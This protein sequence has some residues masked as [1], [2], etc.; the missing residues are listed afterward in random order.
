MST[1]EAHLQ[2]LRLLQKTPQVNQRGLA[3]E[4]GISLGKANYCLKA[5]IGKGL[6]KVQNFRNSE[7]KLSYAYL[8]TPLGIAEKAN[9]TAQFLKY[10][11]AEYERLD[12]EIQLLR[13]EFRDGQYNDLP[14]HSVEAFDQGVSDSSKGA[15][16]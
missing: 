11:L 7:N 13:N 6:V 3:E 15:H 8:L 5:L 12:L 2:V 16:A 4:L 14:I 9:L 1:E 10:K